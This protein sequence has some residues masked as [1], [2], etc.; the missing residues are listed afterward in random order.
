MLLIVPQGKKA[1]MYLMEKKMCADK[2]TSGIH[3]SVA[4]FEFNVNE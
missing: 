3:Y 1:V 2:L 4:S